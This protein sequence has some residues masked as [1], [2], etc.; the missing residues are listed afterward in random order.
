MSST[1]KGIHNSIDL[2]HPEGI[3]KLIKESKK[4]TPVKVYINGELSH[5]Q[6]DTIKIFGHQNMWILIGEYEEV[7]K[8]LFENQHNIRYYHLENDRRNS[9][10]P[11]LDTLTLQARIEPGAIIRD[12]VIIQ[13]NAVI[14]MGA[15]IN[16]GA[17]IGENTMIDM[18]CVIG[19]RGIIG[20]NVHVGAGTVVAG[21]LEPPSSTPVIIEDNV[22]IGANSVILEGVRVGEGAVIAA[23]SIVT[24]DVPPN[25]V[26]AGT[27]ARV[28]K[29]KDSKTSDKVKLL[30]E[31]RG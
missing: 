21:V 28:I 8:I 23:G 2:S 20:K 30:E 27:P 1:L 25:T 26:A 19:A 11:L 15:V 29:M 10:I 14:M 7:Q 13:K 22:F 6:S 4:S 18:N 16:I 5:V 3:A 12:G 31:L 24:K 9:A 17:E